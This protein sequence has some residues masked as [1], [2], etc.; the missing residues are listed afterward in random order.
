MAV[1]RDNFSDLRRGAEAIG[2]VGLQSCDKV[3]N[4]FDGPCT[5]HSAAGLNP[6]SDVLESAQ[7]DSGK[8]RSRSLQHVDKSGKDSAGIGGWLRRLPRRMSGAGL[9]G[10][11]NAPPHCKELETN[12]N[13]VDDSFRVR[14]PRR[15]VR[16]DDPLEVQQERERMELSW[17]LDDP[18]FKVKVAFRFTIRG[19]THHVALAHTRAI[20]TLCVDGQFVHATT[21]SQDPTDQERNTIYFAVAHLDGQEYEAV[22]SMTWDRWRSKWWHE[23]LV[24]DVRVPPCWSKHRG[25][26]ELM[27]PV[28]EVHT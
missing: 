8:D 12:P 14:A 9:V 28:P 16:V 1:L 22:M 26:C 2:E 10:V 4:L 23:L 19:E 20:W 15:L 24:N 21:H 11:V 5:R 6:R 13:E 3:A 27:A 18:A 25:A 7:S 17:W